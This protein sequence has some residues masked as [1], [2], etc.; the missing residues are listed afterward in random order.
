MSVVAA[1]QFKLARARKSLENAYKDGDW[2][3]IKRWDTELA[4]C[5]NV[6]FEENDRDVH[7]LINQL[8]GVL[9]TYSKI[10]TELPEET[11][12]HFVPDC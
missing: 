9:T 5:L 10:V 12:R 7:T 3:E 6:L 1:S 2:D 11:V 8:E 4:N